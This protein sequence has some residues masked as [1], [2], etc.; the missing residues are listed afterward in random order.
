MQQFEPPVPTPTR[1]VVSA[2]Q[3]YN[4][5]RWEFERDVLPVDERAPFVCEC[6]SDAC[7]DSL[8]LT[9]YEFEAAHMCPAWCAVRPGHMLEDDGG[10]IV[11]HEP[12]FW[13]VE[14]LPLPS[15]P[16]SSARANRQIRADHARRAANP[17]NPRRSFELDR[18]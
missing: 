7:L 13:V 14:L 4:R 18:S 16:A 11:I 10:R 9:M 15:A 12:H 1:K 8:D 5:R 6:T 17:Q 3:G 2:W